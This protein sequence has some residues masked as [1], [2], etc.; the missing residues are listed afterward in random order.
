MEGKVDLRSRLGEKTQHRRPVSFRTQAKENESDSLPPREEVFD[1]P[2]LK[3]A[4]SLCTLLFSLNR[5]RETQR[6]V[7]KGSSH[8]VI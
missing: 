8:R 5:L 7:S 1:V 6:G 2:V 3:Q 4:K